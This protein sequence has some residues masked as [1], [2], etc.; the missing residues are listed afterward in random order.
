MK[1]EREVDWIVEY[2]QH[3]L[4]ENEMFLTEWTPQLYY[5]LLHAYMYT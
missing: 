3:M 4:D 2:K 1:A 5:P